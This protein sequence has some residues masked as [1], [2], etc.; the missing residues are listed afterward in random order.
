M[1]AP[2]MMEKRQLPRAG[3]RNEAEQDFDFLD[4]LGDWIEYLVAMHALH[5]GDAGSQTKYERQLKFLM[6][7]RAGANANINHNWLLQHYYSTAAAPSEKIQN[8][9]AHAVKKLSEQTPKLSADSLKRVATMQEKLDSLMSNS[10][11]S[12][13]AIAPVQACYRNQ[14]NDQASAYAMVQKALACE[15]L[16]FLQG[17]PGTGKTTAI[18]E[19]VL[20]TLQHN[21]AARILITSETHVAVDNALDRLC[22]LIA[23][24]RL[25]LVMRYPEYTI[26][27]FESNDTPS[28]AALVRLEKIWARSRAFDAELARE[29]EPRAA[30]T[31]KSGGELSAA[32]RI[33]NYMRRNLGDLHQIIGV[34]CNQIEHLLD[35][36]S[37]IFDLVIIDECS[38]A[39]LPEWLMA[40]SVGRKGIMVGDH[41]QLPP[42]FCSEST[43]V[44]NAME[45]RKE[46]LVRDGVIERI[47]TNFPDERKGTLLT[48][49]RMLPHIG[50]FISKHFYAGKLKH[51]R[52]AVS[53][54]FTFF[55]WL[56]Y[57]ARECRVPEFD[58][59]DKRKVL[60][61]D[62]EIELI[63]AELQKM[64][65]ILKERQQK[66][67]VAVI[68]PFKQ[69][70]EALEKRLK[71]IRS[72]VLSI[73][74]DTVDAFQGR[75]ADVVFFSFVR[76][77]GSPRFF[78]DDRR[79]NVALSRA[80]DSVYLVGAIDY[81]ERVNVPAM[82]SL[83][84]IRQSPAH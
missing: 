62:R 67:S 1:N 14:M 42:T 17:P 59:D 73:E 37:G 13:V 76:T 68:T 78:S 29:L 31:P 44:L 48:Q 33:P 52:K 41:N 72:N 81:L 74:I 8:V 19:I 35:D 77:T 39:T 65:A 28:T 43:E 66:I 2:E 45:E 83:T 75:E 55:G 11:Q 47:F 53:H 16:F 30:R 64:A 61:N 71:H 50:N 69:Q 15:D 18:V 49:Y 10:A 80:R 7:F 5:E 58:G 63:A 40:L 25:Q 4:H 21:P 27:A 20:Q 56:G 70:R 51:H 84:R 3:A 60:R 82:R 54:D 6:R 12:I 36:E 9:N 32:E 46:R 24:D 38:K 22:K 79:L 23:T 57:S 26:T 34:T